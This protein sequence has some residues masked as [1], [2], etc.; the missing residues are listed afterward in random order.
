M[1]G[2]EDHDDCRAGPGD[3][4]DQSDL[5]G[6]PG[7]RVLDH[8]RQPEPEAV[9]AH[10]KAEVDKAQEPDLAALEGV[11]EVVAGLAP[12]ALGVLFLLKPVQQKAPFIAG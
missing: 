3:H 10:H 1:V 8:L 6:V 7:E 5:P 2:V 12:A 11:D 4:R 9:V